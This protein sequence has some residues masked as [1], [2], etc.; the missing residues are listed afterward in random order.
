[1]PEHAYNISQRRSKATDELHTQGTRHRELGK[2]KTKGAAAEARPLGCHRGANR[3][4]CE[5]RESR[6]GTHVTPTEGGGCPALVAGKRREAAPSHVARLVGQPR[7]GVRP[8]LLADKRREA[9]T[10]EPLVP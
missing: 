3:G 5:V 7:E 2:E 10:P 1:V 8:A 6:H 4:S 9:A